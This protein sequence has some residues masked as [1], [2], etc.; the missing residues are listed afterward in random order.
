MAG[1]EDVSPEERDRIKKQ[2]KINI[3]FIRYLLRQNPE[4]N[5]NSE[6][7][8]LHILYRNSIVDFNEDRIINQHNVLDPD[9]AR[10]ISYLSQDTIIEEFMQLDLETKVYEWTDETDPS[11]L[12]PMD[13]YTMALETGLADKV[14][15]SNF[16]LRFARR[17]RH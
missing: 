5:I 7:E 16:Y 10:L 11:Y 14:A 1:Y 2:T 15:Q 6:F 17:M 4:I 13:P 8:F 3:L 12:S 9:S